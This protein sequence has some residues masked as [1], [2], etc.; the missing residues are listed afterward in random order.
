MGSNERDNEKPSHQVTVRS[1]ALGKYEVTQ[2]QWKAV[3]GSNPSNFS[4]CGDNCPA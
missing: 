1:F 3:M 4:D 2:G